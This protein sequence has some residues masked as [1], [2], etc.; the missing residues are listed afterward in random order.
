VNKEDERGEM[1][2]KQDYA[3]CVCIKESY[4]CVCM[5]C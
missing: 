1:R 5:C 2:I 4:V 3:Y